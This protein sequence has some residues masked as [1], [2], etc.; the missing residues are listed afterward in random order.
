MSIEAEDKR[1]VR[2][3]ARL[4]TLMDVVYGLT[5]WRLF[6][7]LPRPTENETRSVWELFTDDLRSALTVVIGM[8]I[9]IIYWMQNN[10]LFGHLTRTDAR[11]TSLAIVQMFC[12]LLFLYAISVGTNY[13]AAADLRVFESLTAMLV[14]V[15]AYLAWR[16]A[17]RNAKL[18]SPSLSKEDADAI[19]IRILAE[20]ITAALTIPFAFFTPLLWELA[21]FTYPVISRVLR[22]RKDKL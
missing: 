5:I 12:L 9:V 8:V 10:L 3:L 4:E 21:W 19:S 20:P 15:P 22:K 16:H 1:W 17:K 7:L 2:Q 11:H 14:G 18:I 6:L 13:E